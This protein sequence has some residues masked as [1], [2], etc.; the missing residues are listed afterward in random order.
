MEYIITN[1]EETLEIFKKIAQIEEERNKYKE[2]IEE[3][4]NWLEEDY[5]RTI[6]YEIADNPRY[7]LN[8]FEEIVEKE[9]RNE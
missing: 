2:I 5:Q 6:M 3:I 7:Y 9:N 4:R 1:C 8:R